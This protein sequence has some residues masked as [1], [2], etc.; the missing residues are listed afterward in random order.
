LQAGDVE[1]T[2]ADIDDLV[3]DF[4]YKPVTTLETGM[5]NFVEWYNLYY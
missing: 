3:R 2:F 5:K 4:D 1:G